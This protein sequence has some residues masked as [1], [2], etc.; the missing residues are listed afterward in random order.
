MADLNNTI[1][2]GSLRVVSDFYAN[3]K[4]NA[5]PAIFDGQGSAPII[6]KNG[7]NNFGEGIR[8]MPTGNWASIL[9]GGNDVTESQYT[10]ANSWYLGNY[11]GSLY[12]T[13]NGSSSGARML[14]NTDRW[15]IKDSSTDRPLSIQGSS[16]SSVWIGYNDTSGN[17]LGQFGLRPNDRPYIYYS[18]DNSYHTLAYTSDIPSVPSGASLWNGG[19]TTWYNTNNVS[20]AAD[21]NG[22]GEWSFDC[23]G[24]NSTNVWQVWS[25]RN[26]STILQCYPYDNHVNIPNGYLYVG[27]SIYEGG[28][29]LSSKY[30]AQTSSARPGVTKLYRNDSNDAYNVQ[31]AWT[32]SYWIL[33]GYYGDTY[34]AGCQVDYASS[35][36][37]AS[38]ASTAG[39]AD[40]IS[41]LNLI[42][43]SS[44][45]SSGGWDALGGRYNG[46]V[47]AISYN[48]SQ[49]NWNSSTY[50]AS[51][52]FGCQ[53]TK[54]LLDCAYSS[55]IVTFGGAY[56][57]G[58]TADN[59]TWYMK[60]TG[61]TATTYNLDNM[62]TTSN[63]GSQSVSNANTVGGLG[64]HS[65]RNNEAN[66][67]VRTD[68]NGYIQ[69]GYINSSSGDED[70]HSAPA[71]IWG[72]NGSD[73]YLR[74]YRADYVSVGYATSAGSSTVSD[75]VTYLTSAPT[76]DNTSGYLKFVV[77]SSEPSTRYSGYVYFIVS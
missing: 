65:G 1:V 3:G 14:S 28:T 13:R 19:S 73:S 29:V 66:K 47:L 8:V 60:L 44:S 5:G 67:V 46:S 7:N 33:R 45:L 21:G 69:C 9:L 55:P 72:T 34:H 4:V 43:N 22:D 23:D 38:S 25:S 36:G 64:V 51:L 16:N 76:S 53:D 62:I 63:I 27:G 49:A 11:N 50:S 26:N 12:L 40:A 52:V 42:R 32:G 24:T 75:N 68:G 37:S 18:S 41:N 61:T 48:S 71:R 77:L 57:G 2:R 54:G 17:E 30:V 74:T 20:C 39:T 56:T 59:P 70:N 31:T 58:S 35:A 15:L 10:S 6:V